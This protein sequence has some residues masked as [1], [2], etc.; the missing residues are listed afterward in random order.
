M[1]AGASNTLWRSNP[2]GSN[3]RKV[4]HF[5]QDPSGFWD[6]QCASWAPNGKGSIVF[7]GFEDAGDGS[8]VP[9]TIYRVAADGL[10]P[11]TP[12]ASAGHDPDWGRVPA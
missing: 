3:P 7:S 4:T 6:L 8:F 1:Q 5:D 12:I 9:P 11:P 10:S 2:D